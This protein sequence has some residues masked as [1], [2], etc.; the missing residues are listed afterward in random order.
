MLVLDRKENEKIIVEI[1]GQ[2]M[3]ITVA[4]CR[5]GG[6]KILFEAPKTFGIHRSEISRHNRLR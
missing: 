2:K 4:D 3:I 1:N 5:K 6:C